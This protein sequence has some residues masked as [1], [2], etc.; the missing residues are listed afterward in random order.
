MT[1]QAFFECDFGSLLESTTRTA[2]VQSDDSSKG[3]GSLSTEDAD[4]RRD[5]PDAA[6]ME[7]AVLR[8]GS[9]APSRLST[10]LTSPCLSL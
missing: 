4:H 6:V 8:D 9:R 10:R 2:A 5:L 3:P 7:V 1:G